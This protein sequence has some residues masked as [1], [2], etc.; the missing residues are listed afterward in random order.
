MEGWHA[1]EVHGAF[2]LTAHMDQAERVASAR[3]QSAAMQTT[4]LWMLPTGL[5]IG[6]GFFWYGRKSIIQPLLSVVQAIHRSSIETTEASNQ[7]AATS[8][9]LAQSA[10]EQAS[11]LDQITDS[12]TSV[13]EKTRNTATGAQRA[14]SLSDET[15]AAAARGGDEMTRMN[16][17][18]DEIRTA[19]RSVSAIVRTIDEVAFQTNILAL[20]AAVEAARAGEAGAG[21][22]IVADEVRNLAQRS[23][24]AARETAALVEEALERSSNGAEICSSVAARLREIE[25]RGKPLNEAVAVIASAAKDQRL[26]VDRFSTSVAE[27]N[28]VTQRVAANAEESAAAA[29][30]LNAQSEH[31]MD[32][33]GSLKDLVGVASES[34]E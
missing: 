26:D 10:T 13:T 28:Q 34:G 4:L 33:I 24:K 20:N 18:M 30:Q 12:L 21:F 11:S 8:Q 17:A 29:S 3:A 23:A 15:S 14:R 1:G 9:N 25:D 32:A 31:L 5:I 7:I 16:Q 19:T 6:L 27:L 22:A 2:V